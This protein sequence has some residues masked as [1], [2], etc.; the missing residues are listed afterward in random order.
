MKK[1]FLYSLAGLFA[2]L[3]LFIF[4]R[5][6]QIISATD[7]KA[8]YTLPSSHFIY[9][10]GAELHYTDEGSGF[11]I[12]MVHGYGGSHRNFNRIDELLKDKF[13]IIR[14]DLPGF[15]MS[16]MPHEKGIELNPPEVY[17]DYMKFIIDTLNIDSFYIMGNSMGGWVAWQTAIENPEKVKGIVLLGSAGYEMDKIKAKAVT[18]LR[19][20]M[21]ER[22]LGK[23]MPLYASQNAAQRCWSND[24]LI[25]PIEAVA[26]NDFWNREGNIQAALAV[27]NS[28][29]IP[30]TVGLTKLNCPTLIVWGKDDEIIPAYHAEKF[31]CDIKNSTMIIYD[32]CGHVPQIEKAEQ[33]EK[34]FLKFINK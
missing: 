31:H 16:D 21:V 5:P 33:L 17:R 25:N 7:I 2:A 29:V 13:R 34:D 4:F 8:K 6:S 9:W 11:P 27:A 32:N 1:I 26:N 3:V 30:D 24:S 18:W 22:M 15:G 19:Y 14:L 12:I 23:G 10:R 20:P 28:K